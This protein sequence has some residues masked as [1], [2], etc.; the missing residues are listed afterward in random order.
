MLVYVELPDGIS[1][2]AVENKE[3]SLIHIDDTNYKKA[4]EVDYELSSDGKSIVFRTEKNSKG[5]YILMDYALTDGRQCAFYL[6]STDQNPLNLYVAG[7]DS[8]GKMNS[9]IDKTVKLGD[10]LPFE[11]ENGITYKAYGLDDAGNNRAGEGI[12]IYNIE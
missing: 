10:I 11:P 2:E 8:N 4:K 12:E 5:R 9:V 3:F 6:S 1:S 7:Y